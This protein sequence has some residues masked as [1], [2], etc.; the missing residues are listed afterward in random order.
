[1]I[2]VDV[3]F[4]LGPD[5]EWPYIVIQVHYKDKFKPGQLPDS[6]G[7]ALSY[8]TDK[9][10]YTAGIYLFASPM[11]SINAGQPGTYLLTS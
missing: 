6:S 1:M 10:K 9:T 8:K 3:S 11:F 2:F 7:I 4:N 5:V